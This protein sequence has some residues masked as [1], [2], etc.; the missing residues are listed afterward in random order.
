MC[1]R[2]V[3]WRGYVLR[4]VPSAGFIRGHAF[5][6]FRPRR[7]CLPTGLRATP[8]SVRG[9]EQSDADGGR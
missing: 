7:L 2:D 3:L 5:A 4:R 1:A 8:S 6:G 9:A